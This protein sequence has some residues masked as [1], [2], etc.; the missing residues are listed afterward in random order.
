LAWTIE[1]SEAA[2][3]QFED[4]DRS[5]ANR[6][7]KFLQQRV[8]SQRNPRSIGQA[9]KGERFGEFWKYG[10]EITAS[11]QRSKTIVS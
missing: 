8:A 4:L 11:L 10:L 9:L 2:L 6:I 7:S 5:I 1:F 3:R